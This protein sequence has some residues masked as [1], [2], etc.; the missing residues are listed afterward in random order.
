MTELSQ[1]TGKTYPNFLILLSKYENILARLNKD[2]GRVLRDVF[3]GKDPL[4]I[5]SL[6]PNMAQYWT[7]LFGRPSSTI[8]N[9]IAPGNINILGSISMEK[10]GWLK[11]KCWSILSFWA[12]RTQ[13]KWF[14]SNLRWTIEAGL[15]PSIGNWVFS[16]MWKAALTTWPPIWQPQDS[17][18][19]QPITVTSFLTRWLHHRLPEITYGVAT[20]LERRSLW[21]VGQ[22]QQH[23]TRAGN[24]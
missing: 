24:P 8:P 22:C 21:L 15:Q 18:N 20:W 3:D 7:I 12:Q 4:A 9:S 16:G 14:S 1:K 17:D 23:G 11:D 2:K 10:I 13:G 5:A 19:F 6:P